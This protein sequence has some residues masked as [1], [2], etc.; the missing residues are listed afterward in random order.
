M[1]LRTLLALLVAALL[2]GSIP[3]NAESPDDINARFSFEEGVD[4]IPPGCL[5]FIT[6]ALR[7]PEAEVNPCHQIATDMNGLDSPKIDVLLIVPAS[8]AAERDLRIMRQSVQMWEDGLD[9]MAKDMGLGW[10]ADG[11]EFHIAIQMIDLNDEGPNEFTTYPIVDPEIVVIASNPVGGIGIGVDP[12]DFI[13]GNFFGDEDIA[14]P[15]HGIA[16]P[17]DVSAWEALPG[18]DSHH[19]GRGGT[20]VEDC[21]GAGGNV[22]FAVNG[23]VDPLAADPLWTDNVVDFQLYDLVSHEVGHC[24]TLGHVGDGAEG[25]WSSVPT[26]DIMAYH[27]DPPGLSK[28]VSSLNVEAFVISMSRYLDT[29][30]DSAVDSNDKFYANDAIGEGD[31]TG[32]PFMVQHRDNHYY[33][34][35]TREAIDCPQPDFSP[36][37]LSEVLNFT[38]EAPP[39]SWVSIG[40]LHDGQMVAPATLNLAG[41][42][43]GVALPDSILLLVPGQSNVTVNVAPDGA[44]VGKVNLR[45]A[46][47][48]NATVIEALWLDADGNRI[49]SDRVA[50]FA[51]ATVPLSANQLPPGAGPE[52]SKDTPAAGPVLGAVALLG[53]ALVLRRRS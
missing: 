30:N 50:V 4:N 52:S 10:F 42:T 24:L 14:G 32:R 43:S 40:T 47:T 28:C 3:V 45:D 15:C 21:D 29:N 31:G 34:S 35:P 19:G 8:P 11:V 48:M 20:Y 51:N 5:P 23:A 33:A 41:Q 16:N 12:S 17:F 38:P 1:T 49:D 36:V 7:E 26:N 9:W 13:F 25:S 53:A 37:P 18:Y 22:C 6:D 39:R 27:S 46:D 2:A 44:W